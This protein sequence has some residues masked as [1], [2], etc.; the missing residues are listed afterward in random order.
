MRSPVLWLSCCLLLA[1]AALFYPLYV[2]R[3]F[4]Y[5]GGREL[6]VALAFLQIRPWLEIPLA[7]TALVLMVWFWRSHRRVLPRIVGVLLTAL[8]I[9]CAA[10]SRINVYELMF[11]HLDWPVFRAASESKLDGDEEVIAIKLRNAARAY[12]IRIVSYH[13]VVNDVVGGVPVVATY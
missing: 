6:A 13:H 1:F 9:A 5:Q 4:R 2:I 8:T 12:P 10:L 11:H 7:V 3:P